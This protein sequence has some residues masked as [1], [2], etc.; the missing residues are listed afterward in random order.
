MARLVYRNGGLTARNLTP[1]LVKDTEGRPGQ[2]P[3]LSTSEYL[4]QSPGQRTKAQ[5]IDLDL[6]EPPLCGIPDNLSEGGTPGH[7]AI[8][9]VRSD[10]EVDSDRLRDWA[11]SRERLGDD[12]DAVHELTR[13]VID[14]VVDSIQRG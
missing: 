5:V 3:D 1:R 6:L 7:V 11:E 8:T 13:I 14:A 4:T 12:P 9:P 2:A 10:G